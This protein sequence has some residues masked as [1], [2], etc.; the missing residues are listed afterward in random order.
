MANAQLDTLIRA[1]LAA[2]EAKKSAE[3][4]YNQ[5]RDELVSVLDAEGLQRY[6]GAFAKLTVCE[7]KNY[8][9]PVEIVRA[10]EL[11]KAEEKAAIKVGTAEI[12]S[13]TRYPRVTVTE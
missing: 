13:V 6:T 3:A 5:L 12:A 10:Q 11:L 1:Y 7:R 4:A 9:F 2:S 8:T